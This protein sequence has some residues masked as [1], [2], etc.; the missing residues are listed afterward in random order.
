MDCCDEYARA[1]MLS[2][3]SFLGAMAAGAVTTSLVGDTFLQASY[4]A[5]P[6]GNVLVVLSFRGGI[7]GLGAVV[8][9]GEAAYAT[10]RPTTKVPTAS[11]LAKDAMFGLHPQLE[12]LLWAWNSGELAVVNAV[13]LPVL[14]RSHFSAT[15]LVEDADAGSSVRRGWINRMVGLNAAPD[16]IDA[17]ALGTSTPATQ[18]EGPS[19]TVTAPNLDGILLAGAEDA[20]EW[21]TRR[22]TSLQTMWA[23]APGALGRGFESAYATA[24]K[25]RPIAQAPY[26]PTVPYP[27]EWPGEDLAQALMDAARLIKAD[28]GT[29]VITVDFGG[30][31]MHTG[32]GT[33]DWGR[34]RGQLRAFATATSAF[35]QDL[36]PLRSRVTLATISEFGRRLEENGSQGLDHGW[37]N[38]M[39]LMGAGVKG[40]QYHGS[41]PGLTHGTRRDDDLKVTTDY[42][43]VLGEIVHKRFP[44]K[45]VTKVFPGVSYAPIGVL[46]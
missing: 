27:S 2:R 18:V 23:G 4:G 5:E 35:L 20:G 42:R 1:A 7:D 19:P 33:L 30:W 40:G 12:P 3:R 29:Q 13:G 44:D 32:Y 10:A 38:M 31:D 9:H 8:P 41:W 11:L 43:Q 37:G 16:P 17:V 34:M 22:L 14:N 24:N 45:D 25:V 26:T 36:G 46:S 28:I 6:G 21:G 15:E 39:M